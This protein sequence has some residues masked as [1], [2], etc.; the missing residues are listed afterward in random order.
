MYEYKYASVERDGWI[1]AGFEKYQEL[2]DKAA[3]MGW[4]YVSWIPVEYT[5]GALTKIDLVFE[6]EI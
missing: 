1:F 5:N 2:I 3:A 4:R 6:R